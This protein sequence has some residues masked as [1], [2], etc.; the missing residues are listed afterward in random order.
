MLNTVRKFLPM[1]LNFSLDGKQKPSRCCAKN[2][3]RLFY[4][5]PSSVRNPSVDKF[6]LYHRAKYTR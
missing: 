1:L 3:G 4:T 2:I 6:L 5:L